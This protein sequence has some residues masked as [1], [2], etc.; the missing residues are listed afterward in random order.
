MARGLLGFMS[1]Y[2]REEEAREK[3]FFCG[4]CICD[5]II[6]ERWINDLYE[7]R[8]CFG[9]A[10]AVT[11]AVSGKYL[12]SKCRNVLKSHFII[13]NGHYPGYEL[14]LSDIVGEALVC[15]VKKVNDVVAKLL[16]VSDLG[17]QEASVDEDEFYFSG[18]EYCRAENPFD[19][20]DH[21]RWW[22][23]GEWRQVSERVTHGRRFF[24]QKAQL[25]FDEILREALHARALDA[26]ESCPFIKIIPVGTDLYRARI[27]QDSDKQKDY[28]RQ[29][30]KEL[31]VPPKHL[32]GNNRM[33]SAGIP[34]LYLSGDICTCVGEVRPSIGDIVIIGKFKPTKEL[35]VFDMA[36][37]SKPLVY[38]PLSLF[39]LDYET[40]MQRRSLLS[41]L[42]E[43]IARPL[44]SSN[45]DYLMTQMFTEHIRFECSENFDGVGFVS[46]QN[47]KGINYAL[48][49]T[50][51]D[52]REEN[53]DPNAKFNVAI[54]AADVSA[55]ALAAI[56]YELQPIEGNR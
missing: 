19:D 41:F 40:R 51:L 38:E 42:H 53:G 34:L 39:D 21:E 55:V 12:T 50:V 9:C 15:N 17:D 29:P 3:Y 30:S 26:P 4:N 18:Q 43:E 37:L 20:Y 23:T 7:P 22:I 11:K 8:I 28:F 35:K 14:S 48:F 32:A 6:S 13:D 56:D 36:A 44:K 27:A 52:A 33:S 49:D 1:D 45:T 25:F 31:G 47:Y 16:E 2:L 5:H 10:A 24:N 46:V 54:D